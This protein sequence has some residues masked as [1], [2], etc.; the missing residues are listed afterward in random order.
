MVIVSLPRFMAEP[1]AMVRDVYG[2]SGA[3][4]PGEADRMAFFLAE[5]IA[6]RPFSIFSGVFIPHMISLMNLPTSGQAEA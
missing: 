5:R 4:K 2:A 6:S 3:R 1:A